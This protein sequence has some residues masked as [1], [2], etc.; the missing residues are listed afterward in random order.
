MNIYWVCIKGHKHSATSDPS[1]PPRIPQGPATDP[2]RVRI[3][4]ARKIQTLKCIYKYLKK[5]KKEKVRR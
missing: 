3:N 1:P 5:V 2:I 4:I